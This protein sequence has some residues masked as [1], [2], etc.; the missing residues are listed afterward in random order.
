MN[1]DDV[2]AQ[3]AASD[4]ERKRE[5]AEAVREAAERARADAEAVRAAAE[6]TRTTAEHTRAAAEASRVSS[7]AEVSATAEGLTAILDEMKAVETLR[8]ARRTMKDPEDSQD[9]LTLAGSRLG[10]SVV[11]HNGQERGIDPELAVV[12]DEAELSEL[13]H[14][15]VDARARS[16]PPFP[17]AVSCDRFGITCC[18]RSS[19]R[20]GRAAAARAPAA[21][22]S[23]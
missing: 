11:Q 7:V 13:V 22:R 3:A 23:S 12:F 18:G 19:S 10:P 20:S 6:Q 21:S 5:A 1:S 15:E 8:R 16:S 17:R 14:E 9:P 2:K 4:A